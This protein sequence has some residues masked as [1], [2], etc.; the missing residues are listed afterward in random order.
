MS[1]FFPSAVRWF[2]SFFV[3]IIDSMGDGLR[4]LGLAVRS[5]SALSAEILFLRKQLAFYEERQ[6][7][8]RRLLHHEY[9]WERIAA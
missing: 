8:P 9:R 2:S 1:R 7:E 5:R 3:F 4:F 6:T